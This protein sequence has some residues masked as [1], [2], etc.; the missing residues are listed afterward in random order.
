[1]RTSH[2]LVPLFVT[3]A[4]LISGCLDGTIRAVNSTPEATI[5]SPVHEEELT[6]G[7]EVT[8]RGS[9]F[10]ANNSASE[11]NATWLLNG[12]EV[13]ADAG[14]EGDGTTLCPLSFDEPGTHRVLLEVRDLDNATGSAFI[15]IIVLNGEDP[16]VTLIEPIDGATY[17][18][19]DPVP[20]EVQV[21]DADGAISDVTLTWTS[22]AGDDLVSLP[23]SAGADGSAH[24]QRLLSAGTHIITVTATDGFGLVGTASAEIDVVADPDNDGDGFPQSED[25]DDDDNTIY[26][27]APDPYGD[28]IDQDCDDADGVD[29]DGD[30]YPAPGV[31]VTDNIEDCNDNDATIHPLAGD[32]AADGVDQ[33]CDELDCD[34][35]QD[36]NAYFV[37][38]ADPM[39]WS[40]ANSTCINHGYDALASVL[41]AS[42]N[43]LLI[44]LSTVGT[45]SL[46]I[47]FN[48]NTNEGSWVWEDGSGA[49]YVNWVGSCSDTLYLDETSCT[50]A[51]ET[52]TPSEPN[53]GTN[54]NCLEFIGDSVNHTNA[55]RWNDASCSLS[56]WWACSTR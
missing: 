18:A 54:E 38:C 43:D 19:E 29:T 39:P 36:Q 23:A 2:R 31:G 22:S 45:G 46:W 10:D 20:F 14:V 5:T 3:T 47:G 42:E 30:G 37:V 21:S 4:L 51:S 27:G 55:T 41:S 1:M 48:D 44:H 12:A 52:W 6:L 53:G 26:P 50:G 32:T 11:L 28:G 40:T 33:D 8:I 17:P 25:C 56:R 7:S 49:S 13:C 34:A 24:T 16:V 35:T 15:D 9:V